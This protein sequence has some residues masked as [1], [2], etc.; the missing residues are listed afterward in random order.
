MK[1]K[2][3]KASMPTKMIDVKSTHSSLRDLVSLV[4]EGEEV[5]LVD[6]ET[7]LA[8]VVP[9]ETPKKP[10]VFDLHPGAIWTSDDFDE[11]LPD[12]FWLGEQ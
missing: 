7:P 2:K 9:A 5:L 1:T 3:G 11:P 12:E 8:R 4:Q 10:R 6:G